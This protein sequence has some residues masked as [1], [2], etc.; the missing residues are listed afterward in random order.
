M[1]KG[2]RLRGF[3]RSGFF[4]YD[5]FQPMNY[6]AD[7]EYKSNQGDEKQYDI[8]TR[9]FVGEAY[10]LLYHNPA[11]NYQDENHRNNSVYRGR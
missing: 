10:Q 1:N 8:V 9:K 5:D 11:G 7:L 6:D 2:T 3:H 4:S